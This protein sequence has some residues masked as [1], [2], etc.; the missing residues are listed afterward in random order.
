MQEQTESIKL[1]S[2]NDCD[3]LSSYNYYFD[4]YICQKCGFMEK[5]VVRSDTRKQKEKMNT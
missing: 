4:A 2:N 3:G 5:G 1:C